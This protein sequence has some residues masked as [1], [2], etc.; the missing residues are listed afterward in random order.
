MKCNVIHI[1]VLVSLH[2]FFLHLGIRTF[3]VDP[4]IAPSK[5]KITVL[6]IYN[7]E[8]ERENSKHETQKSKHR[9]H[10]L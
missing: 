7:T 3:A 10:K 5:E 6:K 4:F 8:H 1:P 9:R 2:T